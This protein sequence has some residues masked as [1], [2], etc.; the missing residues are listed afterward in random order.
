MMTAVEKVRERLRRAVSALETASIP[1]AVVGGHAV[2]AWVA[3]A[4]ETAVRNTRDVDILLRR[5][6]LARAE[7]ALGRSGFV[8][9][10]VA[11]I[12]MFLDG[13]DAK[14]RDAVHVIFAGERVRSTDAQPAPDV[15]ELKPTHS[16]RVASLDA[17]VRMK[18]TSFRDKD[19]THLR[20]M[21]DVGLVDPSWL[22]RLP[23]VL[24]E[25]LQLLLE[26][27]DG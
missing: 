16:F 2:A 9:R 1:Y 25:R 22:D 7:E 6:D 4:D 19:R 20:D 21:I 27:P 12:D 10:C 24:A 15:D 17:L 8:H 13:V 26:T 5:D 11:G 3:E 14:A 18:L 23:A